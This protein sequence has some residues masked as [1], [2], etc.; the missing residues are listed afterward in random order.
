[1]KK[2]FKLLAICL[3]SLFN[4]CNSVEP[5]SG[6]TIDLKLEDVSC[7]E[8]WIK[9]TTTNFQLPTTV[10]LKQNSQVIKTINLD[11]ADSLIYVDSLL[12]NSSYSFLATNSANRVTS[13]QLQVA[14]LD[15]TSQNFTFET[16]EFGDEYSSSYFNDVWVFDENNIWAVG[17]ISPEDTTINGTHI[18]NPNIIKW[19][20]MGWKLQPYSGTSSGI[21]GIW[22]V[23]TALIYFASGNV[24][25]YQNGNYTNI[26]VSGNWT[27][28][29]SI[30]KLWGSSKNNIWGIGPWGTIVH[31]DGQSWTK[32]DFDTQWLLYDLTGN[33]KTGRAYAVARN[34]NFTTI[35][36]ELK[37]SSE[38]EIIYNSDNSPVSIQ[39]FSLSMV[40]DNQLYIASNKIASLDVNTKEVKLLY[41]LPTGLGIETMTSYRSNDI[42]LFG[43]R[44]AEGQKMVHFNGIRFQT[45][46][47][48]N[49]TGIIYGGTKAINNL[50]VMGEYL[51][52]KATL[53]KVTR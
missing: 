48:S 46:D 30:E 40:N 44:Y 19:D 41:Q 52:N 27:Q 43:T 38:T 37:N 45:F 16:F 25:K 49:F 3:L 28:G 8:A 51:N 29:Q 33:P 26:V 5:P 4:S 42:Y 17:Y 18:S 12:P 14:T 6:Q 50:A 34:I 15:T 9:L 23:D 36:I 13:N 21:Y 7:T 35:V 10:T 2:A 24:I 1:M 53:I 47:L 20:G 11:K 31:F 22:A 39:A 32:I